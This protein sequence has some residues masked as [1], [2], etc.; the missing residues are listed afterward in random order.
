MDRNGQGALEMANQPKLGSGV[1]SQALKE[2]LAKQ[3][4][5]SGP[6]ALAASIGAKKYGHPKM[7]KMAAN[8]KKK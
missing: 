1:R 7:A 6:A 3:K 4:G 2:K 5:V 8:G